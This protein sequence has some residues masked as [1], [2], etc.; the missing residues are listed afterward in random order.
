MMMMIMI[1]MMKSKTMDEDVEDNEDRWRSGYA[2]DHR[3]HPWFYP[4]S[5]SSLSL[6]KIISLS[7]SNHPSIYL[8]IQHQTI[9][10][11]YILNRT[12]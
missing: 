1:K 11:S 5:L 7:S 8:F 2:S 12:C 6:H 4:S 9:N 10:Q 3:R